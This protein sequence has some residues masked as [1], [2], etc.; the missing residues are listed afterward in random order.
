[1]AMTNRDDA[2]LRRYREAS[3]GLDERPSD[4]TR[5]AILAAAARAV[6]AR[7]TSADAPRAS[8]RR[9]WPLAAAATVLL[10]TLAAL[11]A[12]RT[13]QEMPVVEAPAGRAEEQIAAAPTARTQPAAPAA[14]A[15]DALQRSA[16]IAAA[17]RP[18]LDAP[19]ASP[20]PAAA[21]IQPPAK[22]DSGRLAANE[23]A[24][25]PVRA[26]AAESKVSKPTIERSERDE[27][28]ALGAAKPAEDVSSQGAAVEAPAR[29]K[30]REASQSVA[31]E[32]E[33]RS[34]DS[35]RRAFPGAASG[36]LE[37]APSTTAPRPAPSVAAAAPPP[38]ALAGRDAQDGNAS[39]EGAKREVLAKESAARQ[40][41]AP[42]RALRQQAQPKDYERS[43]DAWL[44]HIAQL[45]RDGRHEEADAELKRLR[46]RY[47]DVRV[48]P[49][50][51]PPTGTR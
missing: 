24:P 26:R 22:L 12:T 29:A 8:I 45:R 28:A 44:D 10:S 6:N 43:P 14:D 27:P 18:Q 15:R 25:A 9:R 50:A 11:L 4:A 48:P 16:E 19:S 32:T 49:A 47:P 36:A 39:A 1:M 35:G 41:V 34:A 42:E 2:A 46:E 30:T 38:A 7:P 31:Q 23:A 51:L 13:E 21:P 5:A 33:G 20:P 17:Q 3:A 37:T 40:N